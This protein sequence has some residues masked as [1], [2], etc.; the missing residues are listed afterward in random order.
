MKVIVNGSLRTE[1][2]GCDG[3]SLFGI[4]DSVVVPAE[5]IAHLILGR[6]YKYRIVTWLEGDGR[7][8]GDTLRMVSEEPVAVTPWYYIG[9]RLATARE[10]V[11]G[12]LIQEAGAMLRGEVVI[13]K[14]PLGYEAN[15]PG[16]FFLLP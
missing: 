2:Q 14:T 11:F 4:C 1:V 16:S 8:L 9:C 3:R 6:S 5:M 10:L 15:E 7:L 12:G 13:I